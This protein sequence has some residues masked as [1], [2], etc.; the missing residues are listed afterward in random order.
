MKMENKKLPLIA[1][2]SLILGGALGWGL[3]KKSSTLSQSFSLL[4]QKKEI[5]SCTAEGSP[6]IEEKILKI[7]NKVYTFQELPDNL[8]HTLFDLK[9]EGH[10]KSLRF[11]EEFALRVA[12]AKDLNK[13]GPLPLIKDLMPEMK[14][15]ETEIKA[16]FQKNK[17]RM[18]PNAKLQTMKANLSRYLKNQKLF[19]WFEKELKGLKESGRLQILAKAP[20]SPEI[21][22]DLK[23]HPSLG[24]DNAPFTLIETSDYLCPHC[25]NVHSEVKSV[26]NKFKDKLKFVQINFS[27]RPDQDSGTYIRGAHCAHKQSEEFFWKYH[28]QTFEKQANLQGKKNKKSAFNSTIEIAK[29]IGANEKD[30]KKCLTNG[31]SKKAML[32]T[33]AQLSA[34]GIHSTPTFFL[35]NKRVTIGPEGLEKTLEK[36]IQ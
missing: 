3:G 24:P 27:L 36:L 25:Q 22:I 28:N 23:G 4:G 12:L 18:P 32:S 26:L 14:I 11:Y 30:F 7:D 15:T 16:F 8:K 13:K 33:N 9:N 19:S 10:L 6:S 35:N 1:I 31:S 20:S 21:K 5:G 2:V 34:L 17:N 29:S